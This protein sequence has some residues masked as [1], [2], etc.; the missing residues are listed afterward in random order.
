[1]G[2][3]VNTDNHKTQQGSAYSNVIWL[4]SLTLSKSLTK[5]NF[6]FFSRPGGQGPTYVPPHLTEAMLNSLKLQSIESV[7]ILENILKNL[8]GQKMIMPTLSTFVR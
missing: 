1:M 6:C 5:N 4:H 2:S 8:N 7:V 3:K